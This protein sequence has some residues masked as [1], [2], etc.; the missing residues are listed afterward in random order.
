MTVAAPDPAAP[1]SAATAVPAGSADSAA[2]ARRRSGE[3]KRRRSRNLILDAAEQAFRTGDFRT[4]TVEDVAARAGVSPAT[5]YNNFA[6]KAAMIASLFRERG[7]HLLSGPAADL[8]AGLSVAEAIER[9]LLRVSQFFV[10]NRGLSVA[11]ILAVQEQ[12]ILGTP[13]D[14]PND[15]RSI[16]PLPEPLIEL[17]RVGQRRGELSVEPSAA[18]AGAFI[19]NAHLVRL[20]SRPQEGAAA[21]AKLT[22]AFLLGA[23]RRR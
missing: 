9:H 17:I 23:M 19:T 4:T 15:P 18:D 6:S 1:S 22:A 2:A 3:T 21:T 12:S 5:V 20:L 11:L 14:A 7:G 10:A 16:L 8:R 13:P